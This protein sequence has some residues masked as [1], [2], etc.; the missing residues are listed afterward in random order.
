MMKPKRLGRL[1]V[2]IEMQTTTLRPDFGVIWQP[3]NGFVYDVIVLEILLKAKSE[4][5]SVVVLKIPSQLGNYRSIARVLTSVLSF[6]ATSRWRKLITHQLRANGIKL[7]EASYDQTE[8]NVKAKA[9]LSLCSS[10]DSPKQFHESSDAPRILRD[11]VFSA[12]C[13]DVLRSFHQT[14][15]RWKNG[16]TR[17]ILDF[18]RGQVLVEGLG[19]DLPNLICVPNGRFPHQSGLDQASRDI[20]CE[21][22][23][24][25]I[26]GSRYQTYHLEKWRTQDRAFLSSPQDCDVEST[27]ERKGRAYLIQRQLDPESNVF[28]QRLGGPTHQSEACDQGHFEGAI[29]TFFSSSMDEF[30]GQGPDW[31]ESQW[32][33]QWQAL[34]SLL[35]LLESQGFMAQIR[36]HP[37]TL[38]KTWR[39]FF[40]IERRAREFNIPVIAAW[41]K[42]NS[43]ELVRQSTLVISWGS[44]IAL[45]AAAMGRDSC[46]LAPTWFDEGAG[47]MRVEID[48][49][50][51]TSFRGE[52]DLHAARRF[53]GKLGTHGHS[54]EHTQNLL[55]QSIKIEALYN[56]RLRICNRVL[57][58]LEIARRPQALARLSESLL[59]RRA[60]EALF[61]ALVKFIPK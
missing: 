39:E 30:V 58:P 43:Y 28:I 32:P 59:G 11:S 55:E 34:D 40:W 38:N 7:V 27:L 42:T 18:F 23:Y 51:N 17:L 49:A 20:G 44:T 56:R 3:S 35:P 46:V 14:R 48:P 53:L 5:R 22:L 41:S 57:F 12:L 6:R 50:G 54:F 37:N 9:T 19:N 36:L 47:V 16:A 33:D 52:P 29:A 4:G 31:P 25:E 8:A 15:K 24:Y 26:G 45:E 1:A 10:K 21:V 13:T 2:K 61:A 60:T